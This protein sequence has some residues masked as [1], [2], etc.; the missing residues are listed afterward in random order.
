LSEWIISKDV[1]SHLEILPS[2]RSDFRFLTVL[3]IS[4]LKVFRP[5]CIA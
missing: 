3:L 2:A 4:F 5:K 1:S